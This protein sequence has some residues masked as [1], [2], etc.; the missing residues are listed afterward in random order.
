MI[1]FKDYK[2]L[3]LS[4]HKN[5]LELR[6]SDEIR[7]SSND[8]SAILLENHLAWCEN[9]ESGRYFAIYENE[10]LLGGVNVNNDFWGVFF[11]PEINPF[12]K[13]ACAYRFLQKCL[14]SRELV[15]A[16]VRKAN[17]NTLDFNK[18]FGFE[19]KEQNDEFCILELKKADFKTKNKRIKEKIE[20]FKCYIKGI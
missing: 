10:I 2:L 16:S 1:V 9:L 14:E 6:N 8:T 12:L 3:S 18:L 11:A 7:L 17:K 15:R 19:I 4:E 13:F 20:K 5:L